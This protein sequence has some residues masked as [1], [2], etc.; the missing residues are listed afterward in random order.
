MQLPEPALSKINEIVSFVKN[1]DEKTRYYIFGGVLLFVLILDY[2]V[3]MGPQISRLT[4]LSGEIQSLN[5]QIDLTKNNLLRL[6]QYRDEVKK[7]KDNIEEG[8]VKIRSRE[9]V[10]LIL[11][12]VARMAGGSGV[13]VD[14]ISP[15]PEQQAEI[16]KNDER[17]YYSLP[18][19]INAKSSYHDFGRFI[20]MIE[21]GDI[22]FKIK[23]F[24]IVP[25]HGS[26]LQEVEIVLDTIVYDVLAEE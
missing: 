14:E 12:S 18:I 24:S 2:V 3:L 21:K 8:Q 5:T 22:L 11:E 16:L 7:L 6:T 13:V 10:P 9:G 26:K 15:I 4:N 25:N 23:S 1:A 17:K 19:K 20:Y